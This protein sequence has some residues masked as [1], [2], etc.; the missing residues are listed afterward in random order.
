MK[1]VIGP[2]GIEQS[3]LNYSKRISWSQ[4][5]RCEL[6]QRGILLLP[7]A[8]GAMLGA[9][10]GLFIHCGDREGEVLE[11]V[12]NYLQRGRG[13]GSSIRQRVVK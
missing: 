10:K 1:F 8:S 4:I 5:Q 2:L 7:D 9:L 13:S 3:F 11:L 6:R 12:T